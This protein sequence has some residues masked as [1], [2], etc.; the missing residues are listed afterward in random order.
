MALD[1][2][3]SELEPF[4][5]KSNF[6]GFKALFITWSIIVGSFALVAYWPNPLTVLLAIVLLG[7]RQLALGVLMHDCGHQAL[8]KSQWLND[9][10]GQWLCA[11]PIL[12]DAKIYWKIHA[13]HHRFAG[14]EPG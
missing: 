12:A 14:T 9:H 13:Q 10:L 7:G 11:Y 3:R 4:L 6:A 1:F 5:Q 8:F 2:P